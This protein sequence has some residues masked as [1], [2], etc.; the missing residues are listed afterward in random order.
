MKKTKVSLREQIAEFRLY[1]R[2]ID[3]DGRADFHGFWDWF[4]R[5]TSLKAKSLALM[6]KVI[7]FCE[8]NPDINLFETYVFFKNN[9]PMVGPLYDDFRICDRRTGEVIYTVVPKCGHSGQAE[10]WGRANDFNGPLRSGSTLKEVM[11]P[12]QHLAVVAR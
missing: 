3:S 11:S 1:K 12:F 8:A 7:K 9:C 4:C 10:V 5:D 2:V 6:P